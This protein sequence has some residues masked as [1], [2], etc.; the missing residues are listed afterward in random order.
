VLHLLQEGPSAPSEEEEVTAEQQQE[1]EDQFQHQAPQLM[2]ITSQALNVTVPTTTPCVF[3]TIG[4]KRTVALLDS[5]STTFI[6]QAFA[7]KANCPLR[8]TP[9]KEFQVAGGGTLFSDSYVPDCPFTIGPHKFSHK[10]RDLNLPGHDV[11][12]GCDWMQLYS[13]VSFHFQTQE[14]HMTGVTGEPIILPTYSPSDDTTAIDSAQLC[15]LLDKGASGYVIQ[16]YSLQLSDSENEQLNEDI[17][18]LLQQFGDVF[19]EPI[20]LPPSRSCD[21]CIPLVDNAKPPQVRP[22]RVPHKHKRMSWNVR[23]SNCSLRR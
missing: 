3:V 20:D 2:S 5:G 15:K 19:V 9:S 23:S 8:S 16:L 18:L 13:P 1:M 11:V 7:I 12:L 17:S 22:Y 6:D 14:S 4:G 21:H 10:F